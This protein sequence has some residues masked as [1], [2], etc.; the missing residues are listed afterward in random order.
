VVADDDLHTA[1]QRAALQIAKGAP[2]AA[3]ELVETLRAPL[4]AALPATLAR[5]AEC[6]ANDF[7]SEDIRTAI[8]AFRRGE[9]PVFAGR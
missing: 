1:G 8:A 4:R 5:E 7:G 6:Q 3:R 9:A 2:L